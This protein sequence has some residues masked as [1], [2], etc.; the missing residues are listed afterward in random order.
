M[1]RSSRPGRA[2]ARRLAQADGLPV[3]VRGPSHGHSDCPASGTVPLA[4]DWA[5]EAGA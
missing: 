4:K 5:P 2:A 3:P 1:T